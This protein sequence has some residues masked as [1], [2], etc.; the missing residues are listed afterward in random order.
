MRFDPENKRVMVRQSWLGDYIL[1]PQRARYA[2]ALPSM[3][4]GSDAT[5]IGTGVHAGIEAVLNHTAGTYD[6]FLEVVVSSVRTEMDKDIKRT[7]I[8]ADPDKMNAC[9]QSMA[10]AWWDDI[11]PLVP[12]GGQTEYKFQS[13]TGMFAKD[14]TEIWFE[15]TIDYVAPDGTLWDWKTASRAY[16]AKDKH[17]QSHQA[18]VYVDACRTL[19]LVP[20]GDEPTP[21][22][23]GVMVRQ[24]KPKAQIVTVMRGREQ[25]E[26]IR[27]QTRSVVDSAMGAW[28][29]Q[30]WAMN[31]TSALCSSKWCD[32]WTLCKGAHWTD[33]SLDLPDQTVTPVTLGNR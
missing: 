3:R 32:Y 17:K 15:G 18:S 11:R 21:F 25:V 7:E 29:T 28:G 9:V 5:A 10:Q 26:W 13:P 2:L 14:G 20:D 19:G 12:V 24:E 30:D 31:D 27:R 22:R 4:R 16:Y 8:S 6:E 23:F 33:G 1:C